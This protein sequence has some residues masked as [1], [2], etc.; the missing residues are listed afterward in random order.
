MRTH[1]S[2]RLPLLTMLI[3]ILIVALWFR[4]QGLT[5]SPFWL[6]EAYSAYAAEKGLHFIL[7]VLP[8][9]ETH[10]PV[11]S[12]LLSGW[13]GLVGTSL[14][15]FR[16]LGV[17][18]GL[19][20]F[21]L[22]WL[23][24]TKAAQLSGSNDRLAAMAA[25]AL[26]AV[27]PA[28]I[29]ITRLVRPYALMTLA[30]LLGIWALLALTAHHRATG[31][32]HPSH[33]YAYLVSLALT[34]WL[35]NL[36]ALYAA[37]LGLALIVLIGP[38]H[39]WKQHRRSF[40]IGHVAVA[41]IVIPAALI[42]LD[43]APT[44]QESTWLKFRW[45]N[46]GVN[47]LTIYGLSGILAVGLAAAVVGVAIMQT[48]AAWQLWLALIILGFLPMLLSLLLSVTVAPI[49]LARTLAPLS[50]CL[51]LMLAVGAARPSLV[52][53]SAFGALLLLTS[54]YSIAASRM[55]PT[56]NWYGAVAW[57][58]ARVAPGDV[59]YAYPNEAALPFHYAMR[60]KGV[61]I[62]IRPI[63]GPVPSKD[64][65][66]WYPTG[67]RGV[68]SLPRYRLDA[69]AADEQSQRTPTIWLL[70]MGTATYDKGDNFLAALSHDRRMIARWRDT[71]ID[72]AGLTRSGQRPAAEQTQP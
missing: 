23:A 42:L 41:L 51:I 64:P 24:A 28:I 30:Y 32:L 71:P 14:G 29:Y 39:L 55:P 27:A 58:N 35:H 13:I 18:A 61:T 3:A 49:F 57:L 37:S 4:L 59:I 43:Q 12:A 62:P 6:D 38:A 2:K 36:G 5:A 20:L 54:V 65:T 70:R 45:A 56:E 68:V 53:R 67:S 8:G 25:L 21:P 26:L 19:L 31:R 15:G 50:I 72:I 40:A 7:T 22:T 69:I 52:A 47:L 34:I 16:S 1:L 60:D 63:P 33:W 11:Y 48:R 66:G 10:P 44:W 46:V 17:V 9:Y